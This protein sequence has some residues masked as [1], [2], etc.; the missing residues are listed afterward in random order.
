MVDW[1]PDSN[2]ETIKTTHTSEEY[3]ET[4]K[5]TE[6]IAIMAQLFY[7]TTGDEWYLRIAKQA[8]KKLEGEGNE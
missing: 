7:D 3:K 1:E 8:K 2:Y 6:M 5:A 4:M